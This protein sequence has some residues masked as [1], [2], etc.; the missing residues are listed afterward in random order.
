[1]PLSGIWAKSS[2]STS[3]GGDCVQ[4]RQ[5]SSGAV[6]VRDSK[7]PGPVLTFSKAQWLAFT[8]AVKN[9]QHNR[10]GSR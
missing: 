4:T 5:A 2:H 8:A 1:M 6:Q 9:G 10:A 3:N 7:N